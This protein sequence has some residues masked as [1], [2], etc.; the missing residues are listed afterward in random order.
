MLFRLKLFCWYSVSGLAL[1]RFVC[2]W[3]NFLAVSILCDFERSGFVASKM[4]R[5][6]GGTAIRWTLLELRV[7]SC[8]LLLGQSIDLAKIP[9]W[10]RHRQAA[11]TQ[12]I[13]LVFPKFV[14][15][16]LH[17]RPA[18]RANVRA[19]NIVRL[20]GAYN[21]HNWRGKADVQQQPALIT[22]LANIVR[23]WREHHLCLAL[24]RNVYVT[25]RLLHV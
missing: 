11:L 13:D 18:W 15:H 8:P 3:S 14:M 17:F 7:V 12:N 24:W 19:H 25:S 4:L 20:T 22:S 6:N 21:F 5:F 10:I 16:V 1:L 2:I 9:K 23:L